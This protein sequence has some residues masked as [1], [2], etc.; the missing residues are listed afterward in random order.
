MKLG[1]AETAT[2]ILHLFNKNP[3]SVRQ[4]HLIGNDR[5]SHVCHGDVADHPEV[6]QHTEGKP[7]LLA[8]RI[9]E[10]QPFLAEVSW[11]S[12]SAGRRRKEMQRI[13]TALLAL[14]QP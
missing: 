1:R 13:S 3:R 5:P 2:K 7:P 14:T 8:L 6:D 12:H 11:R 10:R 9:A 4:P